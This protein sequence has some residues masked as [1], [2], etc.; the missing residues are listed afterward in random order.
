M[1]VSYPSNFRPYIID[2]EASGFGAHSYPIEVG[3]ALD[4]SERFC[5][6]I[7]P[8]VDWQHWDAS[9]EAV[10]H[11]SRQVLHEHGKPVAVVAEELNARLGGKFVFSDGWVVD[12]PWLIRLFAEARVERRFSIHDLQ[13]ILSEE[14]MACWHDVKA[15]VSAE[16]NL[17]RHRAS[18]DAF[19]VQETFRRTRDVQSRAG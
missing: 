9:A 13:T 11:I 6:L 16:L 17:T 14:Q 15:V 7:T 5:S 2:V 19:V 1:L 10:H 12:E 8:A 3:L 18:N 4:E